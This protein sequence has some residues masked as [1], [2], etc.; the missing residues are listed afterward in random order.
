MSSSGAK[1]WYVDC[2]SGDD[3]NSGAFGSPKATIRAAMANA[4]SGDIVYVAPGTYGAS[5]GTQAATSKVAARVVI[6]SGVT[7]ESTAGAESTLIVGAEATGDS[8]D[9]ETY[10]TGAN[11]VR[12]VYANSGATVRGFTLTG[13]HTVGTGDDSGN[14]F[15]SAFYSA[16]ERAAFVEDC[17][18]SNNVAYRGT[19]NQAV[20]RRCRILDNI[21]VN[22]AQSG[23]AGYKCSLY[24]CVIDRNGGSG[25]VS[26]SSDIVNCTF[27]NS[28][29]NLYGKAN[30]RVVYT[31]GDRSLVNCAILGGGVEGGTSA[32]YLTNCLLV[33]SWTWGDSYVP[34]ANK[35]TSIV[36]NTVEIGLDANYRPRHG[37]VVVDAGNNELSVGL[38]GEK[39]IYGMP[40]VVNGK[41]DIGA[42]EY[43]PTA[44]YVDC[45]NGN[46]A[47]SGAEGSPKA[48]IRAAIANA[49]GGD[50]VYVAPGTYGAAEGVQPATGKVGARVVV[51]EDVTL[52]GTGGAENTFIVGANATG[53]Q[54]DNATCGTGANAVRCVYAQSGAVVRGFTL[55]GGRTVGTGEDSGNGLGSAFY[56]ATER[57]A[58]IEDCIVSNNAAFRGTINQAIVRRCR[59]LDNIG[60]NNAQSG[61]AGYKCSLYGCVIDRNGGS[62]TVSYSSDIVNCTFGNSNSNLYGKANFRVVY[63]SGDRSLVNCAILGGGVEGGTSAL[64][65]TNCLLVTSWTW[66]DSYV[67]AA[68]KSTSIVTNT[69][70]IGL[71][72]NYRPRHGSVVVDAGNNEL[73]VGLLGEKDIYGM[74][75]VVNGKIDIGAAEYVAMGLMLLFR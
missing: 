23:A 4:T 11:A 50:V 2:A 45:S 68:N 3:A 31:S 30:F 62:G 61:A 9:N 35:S 28:N 29:S 8:I 20:V 10:K 65:L 12:C 1:N 51:P 59:I 70:E 27:G 22:N 34:A 26:Y 47:N 57:T 64:Y 74:P 33:T 42:A 60:V 66:G 40:R 72:A 5:E 32:L 39:D 71:D 13:G 63:T 38:L 49:V 48:T 75:R 55:T 58:T 14:G 7:L 56:S 53:D 37:S 36:T 17:I 15:G 46:D 43:A 67:P 24:G 73:S 16:T 41:I 6:P 19:I 54:I 18:V 21:G 52:V 69:V 44:W 25:T